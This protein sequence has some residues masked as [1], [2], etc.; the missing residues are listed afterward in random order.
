MKKKIILIIASFTISAAS[1]TQTTQINSN[2]DL[3][4][5][6]KLNSSK[7]ILKSID[8]RLWVSDGTAAGTF[9]LSATLTYERSGAV[10]NNHFIFPGMTTASGNEL[11]IT[12]GTVAG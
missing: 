6:A 2:N 4:P 11:W 8:N 5:V 3:T 10:L 12:D 9:Q 1:F 7:A